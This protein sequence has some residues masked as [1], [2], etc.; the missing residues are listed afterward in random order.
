MH[1]CIKKLFSPSRK[2]P[3]GKIAR[4]LW[5]SIFRLF[6][7]EWIMPQQVVKLLACARGQFGSHCNLEVWRMVPFWLMWCILKERND[8]NLEDCVRTMIE[9]QVIMFKSLYV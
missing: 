3:S 6:G 5:V 7:I 8:Q 2:L 9:L 4:G 1:I